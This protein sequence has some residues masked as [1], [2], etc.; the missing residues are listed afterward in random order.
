MTILRNLPPVLKG[1]SVFVPVTLMTAI[2]T[3][4]FEV[5]HLTCTAQDI[6][7][8]S[9][10]HGSRTILPTQVAAYILLFEIE[11]RIREYQLAMPYEKYLSTPLEMRLNIAWSILRPTTERITE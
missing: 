2:Q 3:G 4:T 10:C 1:V 9:D 11:K 6:W 5:L 7:I 8:W